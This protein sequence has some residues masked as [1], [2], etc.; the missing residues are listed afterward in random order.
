VYSHESVVNWTYKCQLHSQEKPNCL[1]DT[2]LLNN[3]NPDISYFLLQKDRRLVF[4][5]RVSLLKLRLEAS[6]GY[7]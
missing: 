2:K 6:R 4:V 7:D 3:L 1:K 5:K